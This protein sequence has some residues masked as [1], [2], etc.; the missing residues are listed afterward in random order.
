MEG[1]N[2][3]KQT[4][5]RL[6]EEYKKAV[7]RNLEIVG[8]DLDSG[9]KDDKLLNALKGKREAG[10]QVLFYAKE[11]ERLENEINGVV[12][13]SSEPQDLATQQRLARE[14]NLRK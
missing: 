6:I 3:Y 7:E 9:L 12:T 1:S 4:V 10:E 13:E 5:P 11:V 8:E 14:R 2:Y